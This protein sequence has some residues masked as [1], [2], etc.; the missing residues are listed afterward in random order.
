M[1]RVI[2]NNNKIIIGF[3]IGLL[4]S[5]TTVYAVDAYIESNKV[6]YTNHNKNNVEE[7]IDELYEKSGMHKDKWVDPILNGADPVFDNEGKLIPVE[8]K[9]NGDVYYASLNSEWYNYSEK[10]WANAVILVDN[11]SNTNYQVGD[12][13]IEDDIESYFVWIPR[14]QYKVWDLGKYN[15][16]PDGNTL[17]DKDYNSSTAQALNKSILIDIKFGNIDKALK[18]VEPSITGVYYTHPAFTLGDKDLNGLWIGKFETGYKGATS[19]ETAEVNREETT[20]VI[21]KPDVYLCVIYQ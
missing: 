11:P 2:N 17:T 10:R 1:K 16:A 9:P 15:S 4:F 18:M 14:Y 19:K 8:I 13:I 12:H 6:A 7:A 3:I 20:S 5:I 21:I